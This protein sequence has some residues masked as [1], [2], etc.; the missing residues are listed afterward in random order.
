M[1]EFSPGEWLHLPSDI[2]ARVGAEI[3]RAQIKRSIAELVK[4]G[5]LLSQGIRRGTH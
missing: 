2:H 3:P 5:R 1:Y 4:S